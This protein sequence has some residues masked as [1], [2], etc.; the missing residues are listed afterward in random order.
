M[1]D[2]EII[3]KIDRQ[4]LAEFY[5]Q[6]LK[7]MTRLK[8]HEKRI[9]IVF[10]CI[11]IIATFITV[12][13]EER[14]YLEWHSQIGFVLFIKDTP[15]YSYFNLYVFISL[16]ILYI[17]LF[18]LFHSYF[19]KREWLKFY[20]KKKTFNVEEKIIFSDEEIKTF[21][22]FGTSNFKWNFINDIKKS[23][24]GILLILENSYGYYIKKPSTLNE[25]VI[26]EIIEHFKNLEE[27]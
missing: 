4:Y 27:K 23:N 16:C 8:R 15:Y 17:G 3:Q 13:L 12:F 21:N 10:S 26:D 9:G 18:F 7:H 1:S 25:E 24:K 6:H 22:K 11:G 14:C 5:S 19:S 2:I 20:S